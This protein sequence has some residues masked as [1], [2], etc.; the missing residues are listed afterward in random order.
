MLKRVARVTFLATAGGTALVAGVL[1]ALT[2]TPTGRGLLARTVARALDG[3]VRGRV[4]IGAIGGSF[5]RDLSF[6]GLVVRDTAGRLVARIPEARLRYRL[7]PLLRGGIVLDDVVLQQPELHLV[8]YRS[9]RFNYE[10]VLRLGEGPSGG[11]PPLVQLFG[12]TVRD[13]RL[14]LTLP[15]TPAVTGAA[16]RD[17]ARRAQLRAHPGRRIEA[18]R[19]GPVQV[20]VFDAITAR[21]PYVLASS[22][23]RKPVTVRVDTLAVAISDPQL[24]VTDLTGQIELRRDTLAFQLQRVA[25]PGTEAIGGGRVTWPEDTLRFD[26]RF[27]APRVALEDLRFIS[28]GFPAM[29]GRA[30]LTAVAE[31]N[32]RTAYTVRDLVLR[33]GRE[34][35]DGD[36]VAVVDARRG[37]GLRDARLTLTSV[38]LAKARPYVDSLPFRGTLDGTFRGDGFLNAL[39]IGVDGRYADADVRGRPVSRVRAEGVVRLLPTGLVFDGLEIAEGDADLGT[40]RRLAPAVPLDGRL[41][42]AGR[43]DG[44]LADARFDGRLVHQ[45]GERPE[46]AADGTFRLD[47]RGREPAVQVDAVLDPVA[48][49]GIRPAFPTLTLQG[50]A[51][52]HVTVEGT[53]ARLRTTFELNGALGEVNGRAILGLAERPRLTV[54]SLDLAAARLDLAQLRP[55]LPSSALHGHLVGAGTLDSLRPPEGALALVLGP[56][57]LARFGADTATARV[58]VRDGLVTVD[59][60]D[61]QWNGAVFAGSGRLGWRAPGEGRFLATL[62]ADSLAGFDS[63]ATALAGPVTDTGLV[64]RTPLDGRLRVTMAASG[65]LD[66]LEARADLELADLR[67][68]TIRSPGL[69]GAATWRGGSAP[70]LA[71]GLRADTVRVGT[72]LLR[73]LA[74]D[75][76]GPR[77]ILGWSGA[78]RIGEAGRFDARGRWWTQLAPMILS[79][80]TLVA[81]LPSRAWSLESPVAITLRDSTQ[82]ITPIALRTADGSGRADVV[83][84]IPGAGEGGLSLAILGVDLKD[85]FTVLQ[86]DTT[87]VAGTLSLTGELGGTAARPTLDGSLAVEGLAID[88]ARLPLAQGTVHYADR[89]LDADLALWRTGEPV[90]QV[91]A[92]LPISLAW[93]DVGDR[94]VPDQPVYVRA[95]GDSVD[96]AI[97]EAVS[98]SLRDV[99]G[100]LSVDL[101]SDGT[102]AQPRLSGYAEV[103]NGRMLVRGLGAAFGGVRGRFELAGDSIAFRNVRLEGLDEGRLDVTGAVHFPPGLGQPQLDLAFDAE[104]FRAIDVP[105]FLSLSGTGKVTV[106]GPLLG[107][108]LRGQVTATR[109]TLWFAD[110]V[111]KR[112]INID[113]PALADI[114]AEDSTFRLRLRGGIS[115]RF[116]ETLAVDDLALDVGEN[117]RLKSGEADIVLTGGLRVNKRGRVYRFDGTMNTERG[118]YQL[119]LLGGVITRD[120]TVE[121][122]TVRFFGS[123]DLNAELD[124][125]ARHVVRATRGDEV[126]VIARIEGTL[127]TPRVRLQSSA[128]RQLSEA[129][130]A[131]YLVTG[132]AVGDYGT[133][134]LA[135]AGGR[136]IGN[137]LLSTFVGEAIGNFGLP[138]DLLEFKLSAPVSN[139]P[140]QQQVQAG[141]QLTSRT[142]LLLNAG[143]CP[144]Q[145][146]NG[147]VALQ[148][149][150][151]RVWRFQ[152]SIEPRQQFCAQ[153]GANFGAAVVGRQF[154][155]DL[156]FEKEF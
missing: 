58:R 74:V 9:G 46:S 50:D 26:F 47:L 150:F 45:D 88:Q 20:M 25:L 93:R 145:G 33:D 19:D 106:R 90:L 54:D 15:W 22:P 155:A 92:K 134:G 62:V 51:R 76:G 123:T 3:A 49:D 59:T 97:L 29:R 104:A 2:L 63:V 131:S 143:V 128:E 156:L 30:Q 7:G 129:D 91:E 112:V 57:T 122:G 35:I 5:V 42:L 153:V 86:R 138:I 142:Y 24:R 148:Y 103:R 10:E 23:T 154:G 82:A 96:L 40:V 114:V 133:A 41:R 101:K 132:A 115:T 60:V 151:S 37:L 36:L 107:A 139:A 53:L 84:R 11:R 78:V 67:W 28:P 16:A 116:L 65:A 113:D 87:G 152:T 130:L 13:G 146:F 8:K 69:T 121:R 140:Q 14:S 126:P 39:A 27:N 127:Y 80:D 75:L 108:T 31:S 124:I 98:N 12:V 94:L 1:T 64:A 111:T 44:T 55:D 32:A 56:S 110:L 89:R 149:R 79:I 118:T 125:E 135:G 71:T 21:L 109:S 70:I 34:R 77:D 141:F 61:L 144:G 120:F 136:Q 66:S 81:G 119:P 43:L 4:E 18:G 99:S 117:V 68:R 17:S 105:D 100:T 73:E 38:D 72:Q 48:F 6:R 83:G 147:G 137:S 85:I 102:W 52:G 95:K